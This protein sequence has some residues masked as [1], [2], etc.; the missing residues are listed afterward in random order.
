MRALG[1]LASC[2]TMLISP[3]S[4]VRSFIEAMN[5]WE[6]ETWRASRAVRDTPEPEA[7]SASA[8]NEL[9]QILEKFCVPEHLG[10]RG[11][12]AYS[13]PP[14]YDPLLESVVAEQME[15]D[16]VARVTTERHG[17]A[18]GNG[19]F[20]YTLKKIKSEWR[21]AGLEKRQSDGTW[22]ARSLPMV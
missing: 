5:L 3:S 1:I 8:A 10:A 12:M 20:R 22:A 11:L 19:Q 21:I 6:R 14:T 18:L 2:M 13:H 7:H 4:R 15:S 17:H 9:H 16:S